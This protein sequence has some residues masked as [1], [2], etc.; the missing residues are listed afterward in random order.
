[1]SF[2]PGTEHDDSNVPPPLISYKRYNID[3]NTIS[4]SPSQPHYIA[5]GGAHLHCFLHDRRMLGRDRLA[6]RGDPGGSSQSSSSQGDEQMSQATRCVRRFA[7]NGKPRMKK[8]DNGHITACKISDANPNDMVVSWSGDHIYSF[9]LI[10]SADAREA[11]EARETSVQSSASSHRG[12]SLRHKKRKRQNVNSSSPSQSSGDRH[13][14][15]LRPE[16]GGESAEMSLRV[17]Y[18]NGESEN[19]PVPNPN[20]AASEEAPETAGHSVLSDAQRLGMRISKSL[21][22]IRKALFSTSRA[23]GEVPVETEFTL[24]YE[25]FSSVL[26]NA[27][28]C[29][30]QMQ[31]VMSSWRYPAN[32]TEADVSTQQ[33]LRRLRAAAWRF[34]QAAGTLTRVLRGE[35]RDTP[36]AEGEEGQRQCGLDTFSEVLPAP[37]EDDNIDRRSQFCYDFLKAIFLWLDGGRQSLLTGF[38]HDFARRRSN[39]RFPIPEAA[40]DSGIEEYLIPYLSELASTK[41]VIDVDVSRFEHDMY[42]TLLRSQ[43]AAVEMFSNAIKR[44]LEENTGDSPSRHENPDEPPNASN[45]D[46]NNRLN[47]TRFWAFEIGRG[48]LLEAYNGLNSESVTRAFGGLHTAVQD[49][50]DSESEPERVQEDIDPNEEEEPIRDIRVVASGHSPTGETADELFV[51]ESQDDD[52]GSDD[53]EGSADGEDEDQEESESDEDDDMDVDDDVSDEDGSSDSEDVFTGPVRFHRSQKGNVESDVPCSSHTRVYRGHC[54]IKTVKDVNFFGLDDEYVTSGSDSG[55]IFI[56]DRKTSNL[57][58]ILEGDS[59]V[60]NVVQGMYILMD[61]LPSPSIVSLLTIGVFL[62]IGH[63]YEPTIAASGIDNTIKIFSPDQRAQDDARQGINILDPDNPA[64]T[65]GRHV[66]GVSGLQS[67]KRMSDSYRIINQNDV[68]RQGG[69]SEAFI[70]VSVLLLFA[71]Y[72]S[73]NCWHSHILTI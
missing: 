2:R 23:H 5:L 64:N 45:L 66:E 69:L 8:R 46:S 16:E 48:I 33:R 19:I 18:G 1:M 35:L 47:S 14:S 60:V 26:T 24:N 9:D 53:D 59:E 72:D 44:P 73:S 25:C 7:P 21:L 55:H 15:R 28:I 58:N 57:V 42:R 31:E 49:D 67:R 20:R 37:A 34:V 27:S 10:R 68:D 56:W 38:K 52:S 50:S 63:P 36:E 11:E 22:K 51:S 65:L 62:Y 13:Q 29:L 32:P 40:G 17:R 30:P 54:N 41:P 4:C 12:R 6:E 39:K 43:K 3:L 71:I 70:T 61:R